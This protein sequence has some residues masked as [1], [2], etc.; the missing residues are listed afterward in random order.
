MGVPLFWLAVGLSVQQLK[1]LLLKV[2]RTAASMAA[3]RRE[4]E[5]RK[6]QTRAPKLVMCFSY[7]TFCLITTVRRRKRGLGDYNVARPPSQR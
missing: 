3:V 6:R 2:Q 5:A 7:C 4:A 1:P